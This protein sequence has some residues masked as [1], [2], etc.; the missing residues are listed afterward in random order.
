MTAVD[1]FTAYWK[2]TGEPVVVD[3]RTFNADTMTYTP[4]EKTDD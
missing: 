1:T 2:S 3:R 4:Q